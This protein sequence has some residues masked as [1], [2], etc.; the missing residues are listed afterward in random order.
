M[1]IADAIYGVTMEQKGVSKIV[2]VRF[3]DSP[4]AT[5]HAAEAN[6]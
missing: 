4:Q 5:P 3:K 2:S 1:E 6:P